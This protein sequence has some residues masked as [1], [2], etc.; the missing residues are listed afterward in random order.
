MVYKTVNRSSHGCNVLRTSLPFCR[1]ETGNS[2][3]G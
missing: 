1:M 3:D 2:S